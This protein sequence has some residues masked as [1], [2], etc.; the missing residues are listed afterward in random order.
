MKVKSVGA[1]P[2]RSPILA[3]AL[4]PILALNLF[5]NT[6]LAEDMGAISQLPPLEAPTVE[7]PGT[8][9]RPS[10]ESLEQ[11]WLLLPPPL[12]EVPVPQRDRGGSRVRPRVAPGSSSLSP[13]GFG[14]R[15]G[16]AF[17]GAGFQE[18]TRFTE[19]SD[20]AVSVGFG[21]GD[22][23]KTV[24]FQTTITALDLFNNRNDED[25]YKYEEYM[26]FVAL[27]EDGDR[28]VYMAEIDGELF[29]VENPKYIFSY[30]S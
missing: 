19:S 9:D 2:P 10:R 25:G 14:A 5:C 20:G 21:L 28:I 18:R 6:A 17:T 11:Q 16:Q 26:P 23:R 7:P 27:Q 8:G 3:I 22:P 1:I 29:H 13:T 12:V 4:F 24:G 15:W 30:G